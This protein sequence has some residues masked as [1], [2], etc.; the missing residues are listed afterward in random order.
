MIANLKNAYSNVC[1]MSGLTLGC[2][3]C[4][5]T[6]PSFVAL[7]FKLKG[8]AHVVSIMFF[9]TLICLIMWKNAKKQAWKLWMT[10]RRKSLMSLKIRLIFVWKPAKLNLFSWNAIPIHR[11]EHC[12]NFQKKF[13][14][15]DPAILQ[16][17]TASATKVWR[18]GNSRN[19]DGIA[20]TYWIRFK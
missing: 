2:K 10:Y 16:K 11:I 12:S 1:K 15:T 4:L 7:W 13:Q 9:A 18:S 8:L 6:K 19:Y 17:M 3:R 20:E 5:R 14:E